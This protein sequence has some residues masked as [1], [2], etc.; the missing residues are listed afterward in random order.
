MDLDDFQT[1]RRPQVGTQSHLL[2]SNAPL[3]PAV[4]SRNAHGLLQLRQKSR[5]R[6]V[7]GASDDDHRYSLIEKRW[8]KLM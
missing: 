1:I 8:T 3:P 5:R 4:L 6:P 2:H 7:A